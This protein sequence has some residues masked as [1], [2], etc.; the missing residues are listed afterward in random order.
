MTGVVGRVG[1]RKLG[2]IN[3]M[4]CPTVFGAPYQRK[5]SRR[6]CPTAYPSN[7]PRSIRR[8]MAWTCIGNP[9]FVYMS[10][11]RVKIAYRFNAPTPSTKAGA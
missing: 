11:E 7:R 8:G 5:A 9:V 3:T 10:G 4:P 1:V 6:D 2:E